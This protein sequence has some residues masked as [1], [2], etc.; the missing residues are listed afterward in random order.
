MPLSYRERVRSQISIKGCIWSYGLLNIIVDCTRSFRDAWSTWLPALMVTQ[1]CNW[2]THSDTWAEVSI[3]G[4]SVQSLKWT[5]VTSLPLHYPAIETQVFNP[6]LSWQLSQMQLSGSQTWT[7]GW[8]KATSVYLGLK[9]LRQPN[10]LCFSCIISS[11]NWGFDVCPERCTSTPAMLSRHKSCSTLLIL[12]Q[13]RGFSWKFRVDWVTREL[14]SINFLAVMGWIS[15]TSL[16]VL[17]VILYIFSLSIICMCTISKIHKK[18]AR[19]KTKQK[20]NK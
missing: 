15:L 11:H 2:R 18:I 5:Q 16:S 10:Q 17:S 3:S 7:R 4:L 6:W 19:K 13:S 8:T 14:V 1:G 20:L 9:R 12:G